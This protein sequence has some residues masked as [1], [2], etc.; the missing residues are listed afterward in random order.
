[1]DVVKNADGQAFIPSR[2]VS[3]DFRKRGDNREDLLAATPPLDLLR[4]MLALSFRGNLK[5]MVD[6]KKAHRNRLVK[7]EDG[8]CYV[9]VLEEDTRGML[10]IAEVTL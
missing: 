10:D 4:S 3:R 5:V 9:V 2:F 8:S 1:M 6:F 7:P